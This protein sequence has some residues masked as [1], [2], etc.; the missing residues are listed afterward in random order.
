MRKPVLFSGM[1]CL[2]FLSGCLGSVLDEKIETKISVEVSENRLT[3]ETVYEQGERVSSSTG[4]VS[5]DFS[6]STYDGS[7]QTF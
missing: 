3:I 4:T 2:L 1:V 6:G 5:F 7:I